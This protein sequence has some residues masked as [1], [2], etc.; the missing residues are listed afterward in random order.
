MSR[1][2]GYSLFNE[3]FQKNILKKTLPE[4][5]RSEKTKTE[6]E[7][8]ANK[9]SPKQT[10]L[11][12]AAKDLLNKLKKKYGDTDFFVADYSSDEEAQQYLSRGTKDYSV[13]IEPE[14][15][16]KMA[17]DESVKEQYL[18]VIDEARNK[19]SEAK[20]EIAKLSDSG[21]GE[22]KSD[23]KSIGFSLDA[24]GNVSFF[25]ELEKS[26]ANQQK[27]I[28]NSIEEKRARKKE[29]EKEAKAKKLDEKQETKVKKGLVKADSIEDLIKNIKE[30]DWDN[31]LEVVRPSAGGK[32]DLTT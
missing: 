26:S 32:F 15:L 12:Q 6:K 23:I 3:S 31:A 25:A 18:G 21:N 22:K 4:N 14:L 17:A 29:D 19:I 27:R 11:S 2:D 9:I 7:G 16:E 8:K 24:D 13:L 10:E 5:R 20:N 1:I 28:E 30:F